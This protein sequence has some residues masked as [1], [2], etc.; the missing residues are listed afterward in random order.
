MKSILTISIIVFSGRVN[1]LDILTSLLRS[2]IVD[3]CSIFKLTILS[4]TPATGGLT[5]PAQASGN[6][7]QPQDL[8]A[9]SSHTR[10]GYLL[11][12]SVF[13]IENLILNKTLVELQPGYSCRPYY[14]IEGLF[15]TIKQ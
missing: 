6:T 1:V 7:P 9:E 3:R 2:K 8:S 12:I 4:G 11:V 15:G 10:A 5:I 13:E 14:L